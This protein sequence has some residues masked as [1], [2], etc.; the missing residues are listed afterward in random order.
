MGRR[1]FA[2]VV[3]GFCLAFLAADAG[4]ATGKSAVG[5]W[6]LDLAKS[7]YDK[8]TAPKGEKLV[9][10]TDKPDAIK[11]LLA[12]AS[13]DGKTYTST[14]DGPVDGKAHPYGNTAVGNTISYV[15]TQSG[16]EWVVKDKAGAVIE[17]GIGHVSA[18]G[19]TLVIKGTEGANG[20]A[21]FVSV[22]GRVQ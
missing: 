3:T 15:R 17:K 8:M 20:E 5:T 18:D 11:W 10:M 9:V 14:Y 13:A 6:K 12:G 22:F 16:L 21:T 2:V 4:A 7:S 19:N 1:I